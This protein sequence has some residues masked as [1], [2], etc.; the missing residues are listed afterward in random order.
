MK[1]VLGIAALGGVILVAGIFV[2]CKKS[3]DGEAAAGATTPIED[4]LKSGR[5][6][7]EVSGLS[8]GISPVVPTFSASLKNISDR[9]I[10]TVTG[11]VLFFDTDGKLLPDS[12]SES[13][14]GELSPIKPGETV[15]LSLMTQDDK[16]MRGRW[17]ISQVIYMKKNP[18]GK[19]MPDLP[20]KWTNPNFETEL[21]AAGK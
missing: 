6:P 10:Q 3:G 15:Q 13:S 7:V 18:L 11:T 17:I 5:A 2:S 21:D 14:Y 8:R 12:K 19:N 1:H 16:A 20:Y 4:L 9:P